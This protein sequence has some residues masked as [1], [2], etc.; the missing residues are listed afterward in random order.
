MTAE[1]KR[2]VDELMS[3]V[4]RLQY[5][6]GQTVLD[7]SVAGRMAAR[8]RRDD[9]LAE[10]RRIAYKLAASPATAA[11]EAPT[12]SEKP[13]VD[14][15]MVKVDQLVVAAAMAGTSYDH[16]ERRREIRALASKLAAASP[17]RVALPEQPTGDEWLKEHERLIHEATNAACR[18]GM[19]EDEDETPYKTLYDRSVAARV[20]LLAHARLRAAAGGEAVATMS[21]SLD[22]D[23]VKMLRH[24]TGSDDEPTPIT[25]FVGP[26][27]DD[28][29]KPVYGLHAYESEYPE[30]GVT[31]LLEFDPPAQAGDATN[32]APG[33]QEDGK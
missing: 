14:M 33:V 18:C 15:L 28:D 8:G 10:V 1:T 20:A 25:L 3:A 11:P 26:S 4:S 13:S 21:W 30:E 16:L 9:A 19:W 17:E 27:R 6:E 2:A 29:G 23:A 12:E 32:A 5:E 24:L 22:E 31:P 7:I